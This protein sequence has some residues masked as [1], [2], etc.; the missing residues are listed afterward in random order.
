MTTQFTVKK[1]ITIMGGVNHLYYTHVFS[2]GIA[3][4]Q[5]H[6]Y[7]AT[8]LM[9]ATTPV[10]LTIA[11]R[12]RSGRTKEYILCDGHPLATNPFSDS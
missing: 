10:L 2:K 9:E 4:I 11:S 6:F 7:D 8:V 12:T 3:T 1:A 5:L